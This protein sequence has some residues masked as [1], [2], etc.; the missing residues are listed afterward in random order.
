MAVAFNFSRLSTSNEF[1]LTRYQN[2]VS[3]LII[4]FYNF[5]LLVIIYTFHELIYTYHINYLIFFIYATL[6][7]V[8]YAL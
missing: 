7:Q 5:I 6:L 1:H 2:Q 4:I 8:S 3:F